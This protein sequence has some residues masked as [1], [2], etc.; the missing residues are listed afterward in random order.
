MLEGRKAKAPRAADVFRKWR[1][2]GLDG[3]EAAVKGVGVLAMFATVA[4]WGLKSI[5][6]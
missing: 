5:V 4:P 1:R 2:D 3:S 6:Y